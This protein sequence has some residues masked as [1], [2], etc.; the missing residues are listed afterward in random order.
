[1]SPQ[2]SVAAHN[3]QSTYL[4]SSTSTHHSPHPNICSNP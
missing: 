1:M 3:P 2:P 4:S